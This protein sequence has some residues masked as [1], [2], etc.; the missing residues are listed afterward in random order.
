MEDAQDFHPSAAHPI[1]NKVTGSRYWKF[2]G[3]VYPA[4]APESGLSGQQFS[5]LQDPSDDLPRG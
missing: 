5:C 2:A 1:G 4:R 3:A